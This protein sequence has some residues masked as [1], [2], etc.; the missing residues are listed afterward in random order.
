MIATLLEIHHDVKQGHLVG[1][2]TCVQSLKV[3]SE[4]ILV[5]FPVNNK[6]YGTCIYRGGC[7]VIILLLM[8]SI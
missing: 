2:T 3:T 4:D 8:T 6:T 7:L 1:P 5:V